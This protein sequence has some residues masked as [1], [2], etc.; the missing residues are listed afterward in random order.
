LFFVIRHTYWVNGNDTI[1]LSKFIVWLIC[2]VITP[3]MVPVDNWILLCL[4]IV[5]WKINLI[6]SIK[7]FSHDW[8]IDRNGLWLSFSSS[9]W[10]SITTS[11]SALISFG[12]DGS[13]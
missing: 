9:G 4:V 8:V 10:W 1:L 7:C 12:S 2:E 5:L 3:P 11:A 6:V 13:Y